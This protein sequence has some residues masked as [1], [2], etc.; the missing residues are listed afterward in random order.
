MLR[1]INKLQ[2][3]REELLSVL[4]KPKTELVLSQAETPLGILSLSSQIIRR[5]SVAIVQF[6]TKH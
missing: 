6:N 3:G 4:K 2:K 5:Q 1:Y